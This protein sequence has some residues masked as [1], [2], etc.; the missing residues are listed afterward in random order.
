MTMGR[1]QLTTKEGISETQFWFFT[2]LRRWKPRL[3]KESGHWEQ[4]SQEQGSGKRNINNFEEPIF[5]N[6]RCL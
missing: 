6:L 4:G 2:I 5:S 1:K 3:P